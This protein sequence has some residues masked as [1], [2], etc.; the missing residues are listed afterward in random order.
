MIFDNEDDFIKYMRIEA[1]K[2]LDS[3]GVNKYNVGDISEYAESNYFE[4]YYDESYVEYRVKKKL[5]KE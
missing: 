5:R 1:K 4:G 2:Y 3:L